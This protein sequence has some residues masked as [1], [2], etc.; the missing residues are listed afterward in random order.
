MVSNINLGSV[1]APYWEQTITLPPHGYHKVQYVTDNFQL[2]S[3]SLPNALKVSFGGSMI[4]TPFRAGMGYRLTEPVQFVELRNDNDVELTVD[5][6]LGIGQIQDNRLN[7]VGQIDT[8]TT[9]LGYTKIEFN[10]F[11]LNAGTTGARP[12]PKNGIIAYSVTKGTLRLRLTPPGGSSDSVYIELQEGQSFEF[13][14][15]QQ[16]LIYYQNPSSSAKVEFN[17]FVGEY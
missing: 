4:D 2:L 17:L 11:S 1:Q 3:T 6:V 15:S 14:S 8:R 9:L 12:S 7:V 5:F 10:H 13:P 16:I